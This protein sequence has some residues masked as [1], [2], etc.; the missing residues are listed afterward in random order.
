M[1]R[2]VLISVLALSPATVLH[3]ETITNFSMQYTVPTPY[4]G[5]VSTTLD[6]SIDS[7]QPLSPKSHLS[8]YGV[9]YSTIVY[10]GLV[11]NDDPA[12]LYSFS[13]GETDGEFGL[14]SA[15]G[16]VL[17]GCAA[18]GWITQGLVLSDAAPY[19]SPGVITGFN[20][21]CYVE[22]FG[23][24]E[25]TDTFKIVVTQSQVTDPTLPVTPT[26]PV[27]VTPEPASFGLLSTGVIG[28]GS[29]LR[30]RRRL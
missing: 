15:D 22:A 11:I 17:V 30:R 18:G 29:V 6:F 21:N 2:L 9:M 25:F 12:T 19:F 3:A 13:Y 20:K 14:R 26:L 10:D 23:T 16:A 24:R 8:P 5:E 28:V 7:L 27:A 4:S 1:R